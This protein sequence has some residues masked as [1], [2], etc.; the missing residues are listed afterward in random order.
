[1]YLSHKYG[2][3]RKIQME[4]KGEG[5]RVNDSMILSL[6]LHKCT[7]GHTAN[8][9]L[10]QT[11]VNFLKRILMNFFFCTGNKWEIYMH[12]KHSTNKPHY[13]VLKSLFNAHLFTRGHI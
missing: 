7:V 8:L 9:P 10:S 11:I 2:D 12:D 6:N 5:E 3:L 13:P 4:M 1:M